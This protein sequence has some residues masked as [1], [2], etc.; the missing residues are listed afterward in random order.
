MPK[1][2][3]GRDDRRSGRQNP[4]MRV[5]F[6]TVRWSAWVLAAGLLLA[7]VGAWLI[8]RSDLAARQAAFDTDARIAHRL[9]SQRASQHD[10][11]LATLALLQPPAAEAA[12][13][14]LPSFMGQ[15]LQV[16]RRD[17]DGAWPGDDA[18]RAALAAADRQSRPLQ[19]AVL[20]QV[21][22]GGERGRYVLVRAAT[23][24]SFALVIDARALVPATDWPFAA[25]GPVQVSMWHGDQAQPLVAAA[26]PLDPTGWRFTF[27]KALATDSQP[28]ELVALRPLRVA[29]LPWGRIALWWAALA[30]AA[31]GLHAWQA[32]R[33]AQRRAQ[34]LLRLGQVGRLNALGEL[35]AGMAHELNQPLTAVSAGVQAAQRLLADDPPD[36]ATARQAMAQAVQQSRRAADV[37][38][39]LRRLVERP[40]V[41]SRLQPCA[42]EATLRGGLDLLAPEAQRLGVSVEWQSDA[43]GL[44]VQAD[45]VALEQIVHNLLNNALQALA[46]VP[47]DER[48]LQLRVRRDG[49]AAQVDVADSG[50]GIPPEAL[51]RLF[52][53]FFTTRDGG[54]GLGL[55]LCESLATGMGGALSAAPASPR[56]AVFSLRLP[57]AAPNA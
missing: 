28:F 20:A 32:Q 25:G 48:R 47:A 33:G 36:L 5:A 45:P 51:P 7:A 43:V 30:L 38:A 8:V 54:L 14:R 49:D 15:V 2:F 56:G 22:L 50:P 6:T 41:A 21:A 11:I 19:R 44:Q 35:A 23:P 3:M 9:L 46:V 55:S 17:A 57:V 27:R 12:E 26:G 24:A 16:L 31:W 40:D 34:E 1:T 39:R 13:Q 4:R 10:A 37:V 29:E 18:Q 53:P 52:E 42:L